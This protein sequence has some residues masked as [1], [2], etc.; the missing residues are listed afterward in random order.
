MMANGLYL[1]RSVIM[2]SEANSLIL[3][4]SAIAKYGLVR[5]DP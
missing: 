3:P 1:L 2:F 4:K 5:A